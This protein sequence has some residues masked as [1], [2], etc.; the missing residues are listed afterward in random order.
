MLHIRR[1][2]RKL[3]S[4]LLSS[5]LAATSSACTTTQHSLQLKR[6][7]EAMEGDCSSSCQRKLAEEAITCDSATPDCVQLHTIHG[8]ACATMA[9]T[10]TREVKMWTDCTYQDFQ[11]AKSQLSRSNSED[12]TQKVLIGLANALQLK[13]DGTAASMERQQYDRE[14]ASTIT[15]LRGTTGGNRYAAYFDADAKVFDAQFGALPTK[16]R[17][18][19]LNEASQLLA[20]MGNY[21]DSEKKNGLPRRVDLLRQ[22]G[23]SPT[24][25]SAQ[26][27][28]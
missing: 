28:P 6:M 14:L 26:C 12:E 15:L 18:Q 21:N 2:R 23:L 16:E 25:T 10:A 7:K 20:N 4:I 19:K 8:A 27:T 1:H 13:R 5:L 24:L 17:C 22:N 11:T 3:L 9:A